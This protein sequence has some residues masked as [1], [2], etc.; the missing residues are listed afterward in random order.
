MAPL[1]SQRRFWSDF[2]TALGAFGALGVDLGGTLAPCGSVRGGFW[3]NL[4]PKQQPQHGKIRDSDAPGTGTGPGQDGDRAR[5]EQGQG[6]G[7]GRD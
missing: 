7:P 1:A 2:G 4:V 5:P 6:Q 3:T